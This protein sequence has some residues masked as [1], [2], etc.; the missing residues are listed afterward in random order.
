MPTLY[1]TTNSTP[2]RT[3]FGDPTIELIIMKA[4]PALAI[5]WIGSWS[6]IS[7]FLFMMVIS[8]HLLLAWHH[9]PISLNN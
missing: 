7:L 2:F 4:R 9:F 1:S 6:M 8:S 5:F 3:E